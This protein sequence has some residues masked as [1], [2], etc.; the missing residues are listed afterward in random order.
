VGAG[1][2]AGLVRKRLNGLLGDLLNVIVYFPL[3]IFVIW[4]LNFGLKRYSGAELSH[5][6]NS[7]IAAFGTAAI[8][9]FFPKRSPGRGAVIA[10]VFGYLLIVLVLWIYS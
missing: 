2:M 5:I 6:E 9:N 4:G 10:A 3:I 7:V 1:F 8:L